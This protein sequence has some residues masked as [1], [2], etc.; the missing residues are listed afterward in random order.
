MTKRDAE[1]ELWGQWKKTGD[2]NVRDLLLESFDPLIQKE[3]N[4]FKTSPL[5][6][7]AIKLRAVGLAAKALD[8]YDP[9]KSQLNTHLTNSLKKLNRFVYEYQ[10]IGKIPEHR[11]LKITQYRSIKD[12]LKDKLLR[13]PTVMEIASEMKIAPIEVERLETELR[14]DLT[15]KADSVDDEGG[16]G[17]FYL[18][19]QK[20]SNDT[21]EAVYFVYYGLSDPIEQKMLEYYFGIFG[22]PKKSALQISKDMNIPYT[23]VIKRLKELGDDIREVESNL[24]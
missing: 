12:Q 18:D 1:M 15:I 5:P 22:Q 3:V 11:I 23:H 21:L 24:K 16:G 4:V 2:T 9:E 19:A 17:T 8:T 10:N 14:Q 7:E 13:E 6:T 20:F